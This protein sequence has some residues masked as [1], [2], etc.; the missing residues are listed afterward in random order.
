MGI[1][2]QKR[3]DYLKR[4]NMECIFK[5]TAEEVLKVAE[6]RKA[7]N[8]IHGTDYYGAIGGEMTYS[9]TPTGLGNVVEVKHGGTG[10]VLDLTDYENW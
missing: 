7:Q 3:W 8:E 9:F 2:Y 1:K 4:I 5:L 10:A 6:F